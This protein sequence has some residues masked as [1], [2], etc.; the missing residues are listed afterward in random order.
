MCGLATAIPFAQWPGPLPPPDASG[1]GGIAPRRRL[2]TTS[3][4]RAHRWPP[5][6]NVPVRTEATSEA[7]ASRSRRRARCNLVF[8]VSGRRPRAWAVSSMLISSTARIMNTTRKGSGNPSMTRSRR[9][10][11]SCRATARSGSTVSLA[12]G[13]GITAALSRPARGVETVEIDA[14]TP[15]AHAPERFVEDDPC[16]PCREVGLVA[17]PAH[18]REGP[19]VAFLEHI[20]GLAVIAYDAAGDAVEPPVVAQ[21]D[22]AEGAR[23]ALLGQERQLAVIERRESRLRCLDRSHPWSPSFGLLDGAYGKTFPDAGPQAAGTFCGRPHPT[24]GRNSMPVQG[25]NDAIH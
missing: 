15:P 3:A 19:Y 24:K 23:L 11:I 8:T 6:G 10:L 4:T 22:S 21:H 25:E 12:S 7:N 20:L 14:R 17:E 18:G 9:P 13:N 16:Q 2:S 1:G 5:N